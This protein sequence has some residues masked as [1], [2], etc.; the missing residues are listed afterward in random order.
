M[1]ALDKIYE[2]TVFSPRKTDPGLYFLEKRETNEVN[3][4]MTCAFCLKNLLNH[5]TERS[6]PSGAQ[7]SCWVEKTETDVW[8]AE[9]GRSCKSM[10][11]SCPINLHGTFE[12]SGSRL[13]L[14]WAGEIP[15]GQAKNNRQGKER[16]FGNSRLHETA[17]ICVL[18]GH[19]EIFQWTTQDVQ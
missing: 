3:P 9:G 13:A 16:L 10:Q 14:W 18:S 11:R 15:Q 6:N 17:D 8:N 7:L 1:T 12:G 2:T 4:T 19:M 5:G